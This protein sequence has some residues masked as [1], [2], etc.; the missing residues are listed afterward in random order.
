MY[1][2]LTSGKIHKILQNY[3][4]LALRYAHYSVLEV[5]YP[6]AKTGRQQYTYIDR[7]PLAHNLHLPDLI[8]QFLCSVLRLHHPLKYPMSHLRMELL[9]KVQVVMTWNQE[10]EDYRMPQMQNLKVIKTPVKSSKIPM[11]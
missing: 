7:H 6:I 10:M 9:H 8:M 5:N 3:T 1:G 4:L 2:S 11:Q